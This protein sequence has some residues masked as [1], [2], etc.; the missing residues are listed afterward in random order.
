[1]KRYWIRRGLGFLGFGI[2]LIGL[3]GF[4]VMSLWNGILPAVL[5]LSTITFGQALGLLV[6][7]RI[8]FGGF[9]PG[10]GRHWGG[11]WKGG[12][13]QEYWKQKMGERF[14][15]MTPEQ[16]EKMRQKWESHCGGR[17]RGWGGPPWQEQPNQDQPVEKA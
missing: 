7:S 3:A 4:L 14:E 13:R 16:R 15:K 8:L 2:I 1:M 11:G 10:G 6:L 17:G 12:P 5:G 9:R